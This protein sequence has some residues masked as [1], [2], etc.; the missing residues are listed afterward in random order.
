MNLNGTILISLQ[1]F[2]LNPVQVTFAN[3]AD[4]TNALAKD[5]EYLGMIYLS[6]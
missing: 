2:K 5:K 4:L 6:L 1:Y 3:Y